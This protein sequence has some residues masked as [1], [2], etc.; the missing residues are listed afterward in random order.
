MY[1]IY[2]LLPLLS[3]YY[4]HSRDTQVPLQRGEVGD[5]VSLATVDLGP[6]LE[7]WKDQLV[8][9][10]VEV[11]KG[12][13]DQPYAGASVWVHGVGPGDLHGV[14]PFQAGNGGRNDLLHEK[15]Y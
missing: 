11:P 1:I 2:A 9:T 4:V 7:L 10:V 15:T 8:G 5:R 12:D 14:D 13:E 6:Q 3:V